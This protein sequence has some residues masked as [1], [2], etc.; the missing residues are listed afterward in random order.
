MLSMEGVLLGFTVDYTACIINLYS[1]IK[2]H[3]TVDSTDN[4]I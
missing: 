1:P 2:Y 4:I 3:R